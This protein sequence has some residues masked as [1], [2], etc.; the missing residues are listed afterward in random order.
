VYVIEEGKALFMPVTVLTYE[1][2][3]MGLLANG[4]KSGMSVV[5]EGNE[6]LRP[7][8]AVSVRGER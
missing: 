5:V 8:Q 1:G 4:L 3:Q 6:R 2:R 7:G